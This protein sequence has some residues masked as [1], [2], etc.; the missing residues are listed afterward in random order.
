MI[1]WNFCQRWLSY[2]E[3]N[4][5]NSDWSLPGW[6]QESELQ[7][8][9]QEHL[10]LDHVRTPNEQFLYS[11][12]SWSYMNTTASEQYIH[13]HIGVVKLQTNFS[14]LSRNVQQYRR[15][16]ACPLQLFLHLQEMFLLYIYAYLIY[17]QFDQSCRGN[18][19]GE[20]RFSTQG[21]NQHVKMYKLFW[22]TK[23][24]LDTAGTAWGSLWDSPKLPAGELLHW[25]VKCIVWNVVA[26]SSVRPL[27]SSW[28]ITWTLAIESS[29]SV[30]PGTLSAWFAHR[31]SLDSPLHLRYY[32]RMNWIP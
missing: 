11:G 7:T 20:S 30:Q 1:Y 31:Y 9:L 15:T 2:G 24:A 8:P 19:L 6:W 13:V 14:C 29:S 3:L 4:L 10:Y 32:C 22:N 23:I 16:K 18:C 21:I 27:I 28:S 5:L 25:V 26:R 17:V 12:G